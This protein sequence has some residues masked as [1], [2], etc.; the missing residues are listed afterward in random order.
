MNPWTRGL[1][2][3]QADHWLNKGRRY[4]V[5]SLGTYR[6]ALWR[7]RAG[8]G[9]VCGQSHNSQFLCSLDNAQR[10]HLDW[11]PMALPYV[12]LYKVIWGQSE[13]QRVY[14]SSFLVPVVWSMEIATQA[15]GA[16]TSYTKL[17]GRAC[18]L[19]ESTVGS[20]FWVYFVWGDMLTSG[21]SLWLTLFPFPTI[22]SVLFKG[23]GV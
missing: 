10:R 20:L 13:K 4:K 11:I 23:Q 14:F 7:E 8:S 16:T 1:Q 18:R 21:Y 3:R 9:R 5:K 12:G 15:F 19:L 6:R 22:S 2:I 17:A